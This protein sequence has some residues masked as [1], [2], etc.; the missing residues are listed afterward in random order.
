[1]KASIIVTSYNLAR[2]IERCLRSC[3]GQQ[4]PADQYEVIMV[5]DASTDHTLRVVEKYRAYPNFRLI[6][7]KENVGV[8]AASNLGIQASLGQFVVRVDADDFINANFL[9][10]LTTYLESNHDAFCVACD[11]VL[12]DEHEEVIGRRYADR[13]PISC[14]IMYRK[15]LLTRLGLYDPAFRHLEEQELRQRLGEYYQLQH[16]RIPLYRYRMHANNK[17]KKH[18]EIALVKQELERRKTKP[19]L[20]REPEGR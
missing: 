8:A 15:D 1:M 7:N 17:T 10:F 14:A 5:D 13:D 2:Y 12:I 19:A 18:D 3:L 11:Y 6:V 20:V 16:L 4:F 9:L